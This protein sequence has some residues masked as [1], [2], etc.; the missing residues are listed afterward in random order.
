MRVKIKVRPLINVR[1]I[2]IGDTIRC[3]ETVF[4]PNI[5]TS[6]G[7]GWRLGLEFVVGRLSYDS[8]Y[9]ERTIL[10]PENTLMDGVYRNSVILIKVRNKVK[11]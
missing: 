7:A 11:S 5:S 1:D 2:K 8:G 6:K 9:G 10:F 4:D 3:V